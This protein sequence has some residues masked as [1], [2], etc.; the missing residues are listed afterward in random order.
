MNKPKNQRGKENLIKS[1]NEQIQGLTNR[2][3]NLS[4]ESKKLDL[5]IDQIKQQKELYAN[6]YA[7]LQEQLRE[8][9]KD[10][11]DVQQMNFQDP[12]SDSA[13]SY[14]FSLTRLEDDL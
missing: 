2:L 4:I 6:H 5:K 3:H 8:L 13:K 10:L 9:H 12:L 14:E 11:D 7:I 1:L